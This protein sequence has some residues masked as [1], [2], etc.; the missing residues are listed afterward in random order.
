MLTRWFAQRWPV[1]VGPLF[2]LLV[3]E[4]LSRTEVLNPVLYPPPTTVLIVALSVFEPESTLRS[5]FLATVRRLLMTGIFGAV[6]G[7]AAGMVMALRRGVNN[8]F[9]SV[10][11]FLYPIPAVLF[12]PL[13]AFLVG[14]GE[15]AI[16]LTT[17][18]TPAIIMTF[19]TSAGIRSIDPV[20]IE[21]AHNYGARSLTMVRRVLMPGALSSIT[22]GMRVSLGYSLIS[23]VGLEMV[24]SRDG[25]GAFLWLNWGHMRVTEMYVALVGIAVLG[26]LSSIGFDAV[27]NRLMPWRT[28][29]TVGR[30]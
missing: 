27:I 13:L 20:L 9:E 1:I 18:T 11:S 25:L 2:L 26:V 14:R 7:M 3:W 23:V 21:A 29:R 12:F 15:T 28:G 16:I 22:S 4:I 17:T 6:I 5:D 10:L 30:L 8:S 24:T 19:A